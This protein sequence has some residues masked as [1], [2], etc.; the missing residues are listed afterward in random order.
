MTPEQWSRARDLFERALDEEP[1]NAEAW[2]ARQD[3]DPAVVD[4]VRL[5]LAHHTRAGAFLQEPILERVADLLDPD[6]PRFS[7]GDIVGAYRITREA[8]RGGMGHVYLAVDTRLGRE[9][10]LKVLAPRFVRDAAQRERLRREARAAAALTHPGICTVYAL[11]EI[12]G[13]VVLVTEYVDGRT[14]RD[15]IDAGGLPPPLVLLRTAR[16]LAAALAAAHARGITHRDL[17][18]DNV[19]RGRDGA[20]KILDFGLALVE[21]EPGATTESPRMT[22]AGTLVGTPMY[23]APEQI[24]C[25][26]VDARSDLW[27]LGVLLYEYASGVHPFTA[28]SPLAL[29]A[30]ILESEPVP[31][32]QRRADV[33]A[34]LDQAVHRCL[35]KQPDERCA[36]AVEFLALLDGGAES[37]VT[38][39]DN[40][41][42]WRIHLAVVIGLYVL[43]VVV[44]WAVLQQSTLRAAD[45]GFVFVMVVGTIG[46]VLRGH[47]LFAQRM[48][49]RQA[50]LRELRQASGPLLGVD[51]ALGL[52]LIVEGL[53]VA[54]TRAVP[55][56]LIAGLGIGLVLTR[57]VLERTT[58]EAAFGESS[59][60]ERS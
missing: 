34:A 5:L 35:R 19:I 58:T 36:S 16:E 33:P 15:E 4:E 2:L 1:E 51:G 37:I 25:G 50:F 39:A 21:P 10:A 26:T 38:S 27:A 31:L 49:D 47:L 60:G 3:E 54:L 22:T 41:R 55:G 28:G 23:M 8:G 7:Q 18:P 14:L 12:E 57:L 53:W 52:G 59:V 56:A 32:S 6:V 9:V 30:R 46:G 13:E 40:I 44:A 20:V 48:H 29:A 11:E 42:W 17:K 43:S 24:D 45:A